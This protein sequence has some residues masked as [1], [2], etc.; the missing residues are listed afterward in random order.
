MALTYPGRKAISSI[1]SQAESSGLMGVLNENN[2]SSV[3][4][5]I[6]AILLC[7]GANF[8][9]IGPS[10]TK[11][12]LKRRRQGTFEQ[13]GTTCFEERIEQELTR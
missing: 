10:T 7:N 6:A 4:T 5:P 2:R 13:K 1:G 3:L 9:W 12:M 8:L 11:V